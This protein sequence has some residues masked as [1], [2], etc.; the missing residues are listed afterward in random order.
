MVWCFGFLLF[1]HVYWKCDWFR[2]SAAGP[3]SSAPRRES[4]LVFLFLLTLAAFWK[5]KSPVELG[6][7]HLFHRPCSCAV[8]WEGSCQLQASSGELFTISCVTGSTFRPFHRSQNAGF[9]SYFQTWKP[10]GSHCQPCSHLVFL[11]LE[12]R[13]G[14]FIHEH[15]YNVPTPARHFYMPALSMHLKHRRCWRN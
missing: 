8:K 5:P 1:R 9:R 2:Q 14:D 3:L 10:P 15:S 4:M 11:F 7:S 13:E 12:C 6:Q